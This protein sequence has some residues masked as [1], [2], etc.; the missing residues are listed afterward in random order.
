[1]C[2]PRI[3]GSKLIDGKIEEKKSKKTKNVKSKKHINQVSVEFEDEN[4]DKCN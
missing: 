1:M 4:T 2:I 3:F